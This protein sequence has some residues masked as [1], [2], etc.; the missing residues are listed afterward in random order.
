[1]IE[2]RAWLVVRVREDEHLQSNLDALL[3]RGTRDVF[4]KPLRDRLLIAR[5]IKE[6]VPGINS[7]VHPKGKPLLDG[8]RQRW[9][10]DREEGDAAEA[11]GGMFL[12]LGR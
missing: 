11:A 9:Q 12:G 10:E 8:L 4:L 3:R 1:M 7:N 5:V 6:F 2:R